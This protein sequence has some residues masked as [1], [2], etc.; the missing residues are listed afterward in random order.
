MEL[1][2][3]SVDVSFRN[4]RTICRNK[5]TYPGP[6]FN[7]Q[8]Q[9][10][11]NEINIYQCSPKTERRLFWLFSGF[12]EPEPL[13]KRKVSWQRILTTES[14]R[15]IDIFVPISMYPDIVFTPFFVSQTPEF[16][17]YRILTCGWFF[18][19]KV[20][21]S[22]NVALADTHTKSAVASNWVR[23]ILCQIQQKEGRQSWFL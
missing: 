14:W 12:E 22:T 3:S 11:S 23:R 20:F 16:L 6:P 10:V 5:V 13:D 8:I 18:D 2:L 4:R 21:L 15:T 9:L 7:L 19:T 17:T 1:Q